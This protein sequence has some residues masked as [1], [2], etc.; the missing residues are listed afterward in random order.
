MKRSSLLRY[1]VAALAVALA[2]LLK[3]LLEPVIVQETPFCFLSSCAAIMVSAW[4]GGLGPGLAA[5][6]VAG[7]ITDYFFLP[8]VGFSGLS[9]E[10]VP[11]VVF[12]LEGTLV[13]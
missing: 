13:V 1:G 4:Y 11:M 8:P 2:L 7:L 9:L 3:L 6:V 10:A 12:V 5:T